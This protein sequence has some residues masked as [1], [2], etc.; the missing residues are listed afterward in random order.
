MKHDGL[1]EVFASKAATKQ[2]VYEAWLRARNIGA[3]QEVAL[4]DTR[5][6]IMH[7]FVGRQSSDVDVDFA[8]S[9]L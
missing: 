3:N 4:C 6:E 1:Q 2:R 9:A 7:V 5:V 8:K